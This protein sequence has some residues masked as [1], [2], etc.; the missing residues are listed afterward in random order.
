[1]DKSLIDIPLVIY[2]KDPD[3]PI[4]FHNDGIKFLGDYS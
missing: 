4:D 1:M 3:R 2:T